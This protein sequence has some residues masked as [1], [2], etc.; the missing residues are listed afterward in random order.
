MSMKPLE[1]LQRPTPEKPPPNLDYVE[2]KGK[3]QS[4]GPLGHMDV[5]FEESTAVVKERSWFPT[6]RL[7]V[8][9]RANGK[10]PFT[11]CS[12]E[13]GTET[14]AVLVLPPARELEHARAQ[15]AEALADQVLELGEELGP[16]E[17]LSVHVTRVIQ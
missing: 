13:L 2:G 12:I 10:I 5:P 16:G 14:E 17:G 7:L 6:L 11:G 9:P 3:S 8:D 4:M 15:R 1:T